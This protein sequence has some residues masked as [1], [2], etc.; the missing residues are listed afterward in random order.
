MLIEDDLASL[1]ACVDRQLLSG[2]DVTSR[3]TA[4][5]TTYLYLRDRNQRSSLLIDAWILGPVEIRTGP[6]P[7]RL[8]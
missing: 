3:A 4:D 6:S 8:V 7:S 2:P 5:D 1:G